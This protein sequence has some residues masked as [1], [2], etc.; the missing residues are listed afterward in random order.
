[1]SPKIF[2]FNL[3]TI[4]PFSITIFPVLRVVGRGVEPIP[5]M[6]EQQ[7]GTCRTPTQI[8]LSWNQIWD[9]LSVRWLCETTVCWMVFHCKLV[10]YRLYITWVTAFCWNQSTRQFVRQDSPQKPNWRTEL[11]QFVVYRAIMFFMPKISL[12]CILDPST[13]MTQHRDTGE[14]KKVILCM[15]LS[16]RSG[17][18]QQNTVN[19]GGSTVLLYC[20][21]QG[22]ASDAA[23][24]ESLT[25][26]GSALWTAA[27]TKKWCSLQS[28]LI[29][30]DPSLSW[31]QFLLCSI[32]EKL[33]FIV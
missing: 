27:T 29:A 32:Y 16:R 17:A 11:S 7:Q 8:G 10:T 4:H 22:A 2:F 23:R 13:T 21:F 9:F 18:K 6:I 24:N 15:Q 5:A 3:T 28:L 26:V 33:A 19:S 20:I 31:G 14:T 12:M 1:M 25:A 30:Q